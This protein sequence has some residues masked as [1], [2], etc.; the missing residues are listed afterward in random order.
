M[1]FRSKTYNLSTASN[2]S[3]VIAFGRKFEIEQFF[4]YC[5]GDGAFNLYIE[6]DTGRS[7]TKDADTIK[8]TFYIYKKQKI[9]KGM[10]YNKLLSEY[11]AAS[12]DTTISS[13]RS[14]LYFHFNKL[15]RLYLTVEGTGCL[16][17]IIVNT[18]EYDYTK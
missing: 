15:T 13:E 1:K 18:K 6:E 3:V 17:D 5:D 8:N 9:Y 7:V 12:R 14:K 10:Q 16:A 11:D 2:A 4:L